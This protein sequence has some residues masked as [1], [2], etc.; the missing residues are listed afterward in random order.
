MAE[1]TVSERYPASA[2]AAWALVGDFGGIGVVF[3]GVDDVVVVDDTRAFS[4]MGM[5]ITERLVSRDETARS[6]TYSVIDGIPGVTSHQATIRVEPD[7]DG[8]AVSWSVT[9]DP[10]AA[11]PLIADSYREA[12]VALHGPLGGT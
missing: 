2:D 3:K 4:L 9:T 10:D 5:R 12:L 11:A 1:Q 6:L 7:A 8:C